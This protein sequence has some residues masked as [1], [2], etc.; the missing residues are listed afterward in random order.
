MAAS[1]ARLMA[2]VARKQDLELSLAFIAQARTALAKTASGVVSAPPSAQRD[3]ALAALLAQDRALE[4][5]VRRLNT[6]LAG[7]QA[8]IEAA[9]RALQN[10]S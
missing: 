6:Q 7:V 2:L 5:E 3:A 4:A 10:G 9:R 8:E 1:Q